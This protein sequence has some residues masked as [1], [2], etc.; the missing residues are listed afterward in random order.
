MHGLANRSLQCFVRDTYGAEVWEAVVKDAGLPLSNFESVL[1]YEDDL[2]DRALMSIGRVLNKPRV[3]LLED[4]GTYLATHK[5]AEAVRRL[6][7]F[8]GSSYYEF[9]L[10]L[11]DIGDRARLAIPDLALPQMELVETSGNAFLLTIRFPLRDIGHVLIGILRAMADDFGALVV[12]DHE[13]SNDEVETVR[14]TLLD[15]SFSAGRS[16]ALTMPASA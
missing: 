16:F 10:A 7:R 11:D 14:I 9:L 2:T 6:L 12:L 15:H 1:L 3:V 5:T 8:S 4:L 13:G